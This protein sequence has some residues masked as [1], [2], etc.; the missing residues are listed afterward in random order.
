MLPNRSGS[1]AS[2]IYVRETPVG[3]TPVATEDWPVDDIV[4]RGYATVAFDGSELTPAAARD[5]VPMR[6]WALRVLY[7]WVRGESRIDEMTSGPVGCGRLD[8]LAAQS[9]AR[10]ELSV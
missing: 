5:A 9:A 4:R 8:G 2:F 10:A 3:E 7:E 1:A 6:A